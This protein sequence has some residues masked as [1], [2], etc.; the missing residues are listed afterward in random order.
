M[1]YSKNY[2]GTLVKKIY[3]YIYTQQKK[4]RLQL[5]LFPANSLFVLQYYVFILTLRQH[6]TIQK[7]SDRKEKEKKGRFYNSWSTSF[8]TYISGPVG[9]G[10][11]VTMQTIKGSTFTL[12][13]SAF[14][15]C[16]RK[17]SQVAS[18]LAMLPERLC[19]SLSICKVVDSP[20]SQDL[21]SGFDVFFHRQ[22]MIF[23]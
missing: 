10:N 7:D 21:K 9:T 16:L 19:L 5:L 3:I 8:Y 12:L 2:C 13:S 11:M 14:D 22:R 4:K 15:R 18:K 23:F 20:D 6:R 1:A 17:G